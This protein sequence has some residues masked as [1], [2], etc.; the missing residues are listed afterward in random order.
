M[1]ELSDGALGQQ[2]LHAERQGGAAS[3]AGPCTFPLRLQQECWLPRLQQAIRGCAATRHCA[4]GPPSRMNSRARLDSRRATTPCL[5]LSGITR[6]HTTSVELTARHTERR[7]RADETRLAA[8]PVMRQP[9]LR[10]TAQRLSMHCGSMVFNCVQP[11]RGHGSSASLV[12]EN[13]RILPLCQELA[14][15]VINFDK[16]QKTTRRQQ[17]DDDEQ[18]PVWSDCIYEFE[19]AQVCDSRERFR[20]ICGLRTHLLSPAGRPLD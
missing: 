17:H 14:R 5:T 10:H 13:D 11:Q 16:L 4:S 18:L 12:C 7:A 3:T 2:V 6:N 9:N 19:R 1:T 8:E 20:T 15:I